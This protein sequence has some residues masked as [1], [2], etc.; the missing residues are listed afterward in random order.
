M[1]APE[2]RTEIRRLFYAEHFTVHAIATHLRLHRD[3]VLGAIEVERMLA[4]PAIRPSRLDRFLPF[5]EET[6]RDY[7]RIRS[8]RLFLMLHD[9][10]YDGGVAQLRRRVARLR[11]RVGRA[12]LAV[13][14]LPGAQGQ[15][16]WG[17]FG[18]LRIGRA[19]RRLSCFVVT[20]AY[21]RRMFARF[22]FDQR[23]ESFLAGHVAAFR[24]FG[25]IPRVLLYDGL[26]TAVL[27]RV[28]TA[29]RFHPA[30]LEIAGHCHFR[31]EV[32]NPRSGWEKGGVEAGIRY[33]R[34]SYAEARHYRDLDDANA[35][36]RRWLDETANVRPWPEDRTRSV[37]ALFAEEQPFLLPLPE[38][39]PPTA[40]IHMLHSGKQPYLRFDLN[41]YSIP[42]TLVGRSLAVVVDTDTVRVLDGD[43][44]VARHVRSWDRG[45]RIEDPAHLHGL[46]LRKPR[47]QVGHGLGQLRAVA[48]RTA[49]I[50]EQLARRGENLGA[51]VSYLIRLLNE[52]G[53]DDLRAAIDEAL[54]RETPLARSVAAILERRR[55][56]RQ[57]PPPI[58][59]QLPDDPRVRN[60]RI[61][62]H[63]PATYDSLL[64]REDSDDDDSTS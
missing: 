4:S 24:D 41:D 25:G 53:A 16:D 10:G 34:S 63:D 30:L 5:M 62:S 14:H 29:I 1:I 49:E 27:E 45:Q 20:L 33:L 52:H 43:R 6:L 15:V 64:T 55:G 12:F 35:Q 48:P 21:C 11:P 54:E 28:G 18:T 36:L 56:A 51:N 47:A 2:L 46:L 59:V 60:L 39:D 7:P 40:A 31:P 17:S 8:T 58:P 38:H 26:K 13:T 57:N 22:Y 3:T 61:T 37:D 50:F 9:R 23:L 42:H 32:C 19:V 44:E